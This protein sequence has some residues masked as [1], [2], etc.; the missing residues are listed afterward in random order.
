[1]ALRLKLID[2]DTPMLLPPDLRDWIPA[3]HI[4]HFI[5]AVRYICANTHPDHDTICAFRKRNGT[6][7]KAAFLSVLGLASLQQNL[8]KVGTVSV[9]GTK[10]N[11]NASKHSAVSYAKAGEMLDVLRREVDELNAKA[12]AAEQSEKSTGLDIPAEITRREDRIAKLQKAKEIIKDHNSMQK[13]NSR[14]GLLSK[15]CHQ[16]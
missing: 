12:D 15:T 8:K 1:M 3:N 2:R 13:S 5:I 9:D 10:I 4:V 6:A 7:F 14:I 16:I 11:A